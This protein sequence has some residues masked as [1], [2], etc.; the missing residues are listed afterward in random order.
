MMQLLSTEIFDWINPKEFILDNYSKDSL[1]CFFSDFDPDKLHDLHNDYPLAGEKI[2]ATGNMLSK[3]Q[4]Q[5][6]EDNTF[7]LGKNK[8][9]K[10]EKC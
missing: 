9:L 1:I 3:H 2:K 4:S 5:I 10:I 8:N 6:I 7:F